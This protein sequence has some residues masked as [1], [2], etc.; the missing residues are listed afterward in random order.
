MFNE[1]EKIKTAFKSIGYHLD[2]KDYKNDI[3]FNSILSQYNKQGYVLDEKFIEFLGIISDKTIKYKI[4]NEEYEILFKLK[5]VIKDYPKY[6][7]NSYETKYNLKDLVPFAEI[8]DEYMVVVK[9]SQHKVYGIYDN[10]VILYGNNL[11]QGIENILQ[12]QEIKRISE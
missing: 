9:D 7:I 8:Y 4:K 3:N 10:L 12:D 1:I 6:L 11:S 5:K 2:N